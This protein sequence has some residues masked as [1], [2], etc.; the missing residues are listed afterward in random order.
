M[1]KNQN[2]YIS[3]EMEVVFIELEQN[4]MAASLERLGSW[5]EEQE[6]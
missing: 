6:W 2:N 1:D 4:L 5:N 3:P